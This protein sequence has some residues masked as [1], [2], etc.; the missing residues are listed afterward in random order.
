MSYSSAFLPW[1]RVQTHRLKRFSDTLAAA[2]EVERQETPSEAPITKLT[3]VNPSKAPSIKASP[4]PKFR[5][6]DVANV[7]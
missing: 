1:R 5:V 2:Q 3:V 7:S 4:C 6:F